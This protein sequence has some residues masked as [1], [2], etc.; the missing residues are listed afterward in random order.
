MDWPTDQPAFR[1]TALR[2]PRYRIWYAGADWSVSARCGISSKTLERT[3]DQ[4]TCRIRGAGETL[5]LFAGSQE[6][7]ASAWINSDVKTMMMF[8]LDTY[9]GAHRAY[10]E[11]P[12]E[13][14]ACTFRPTWSGG[15]VSE[16]GCK[17]AETRIREDGVWLPGGAAC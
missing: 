4:S 9:L 8:I 14:S 1:K 17:V 10:H 5:S 2:R 3:L 7:V 16:G 15:E 11:Q 6:N 13:F 12:E